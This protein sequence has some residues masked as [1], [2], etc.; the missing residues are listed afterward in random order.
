MAS[1]LATDYLSNDMPRSD[2]HRM[3]LNRAAP[4]TVTTH[5]VMMSRLTFQE[6]LVWL[7]PREAPT[8]AAP[9]RW[10]VEMGSPSTLDMPSEPLSSTRVE[11]TSRRTDTSV[12]RITNKS[13]IMR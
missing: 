6:I 11:S 10:V 3:T 13:R 4:G 7:L 8:K 12:A 9:L 5:A 2:H 1:G